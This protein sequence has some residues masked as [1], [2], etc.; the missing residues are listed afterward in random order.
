M[1]FKLSTICICLLL[2]AIASYCLAKEEEKKKLKLVL[3]KLD[4]IKDA[5]H[6]LKTDLTF[7]KVGEEEVKINGVVD[8]LEDLDDEYMID[9]DVLHADE[10]DGEYK[11]VIGIAN[12]GF[13]KSW[14]INIKIFLRDFK[15]SCQCS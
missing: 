4:K 14:L 10:K 15:K 2:I 11:K 5:E 8:Q 13:V 6:F 9:V 12:Q 7:D 1:D 3:D